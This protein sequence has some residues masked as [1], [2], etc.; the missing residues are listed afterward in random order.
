MTGPSSP[1]L[2]EAEPN[3][4]MPPTS[5]NEDFSQTSEHSASSDMPKT[6]HIKTASEMKITS[7]DNFVEG[8]KEM[9]K[10]QNQEKLVD[11]LVRIC[12]LIP[13]H[14]LQYQLLLRI[15][16]VSFS[17]PVSLYCC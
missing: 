5:Y 17:S 9:A 12:Y 8:M 7:I 15:V 10:L 2:Q 14:H 3:E 6:R 16:T 11:D 1:G 4:N 13:F